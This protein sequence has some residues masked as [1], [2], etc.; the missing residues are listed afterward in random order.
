MKII[1][2]ITARSG[3][4]LIPD[5]NIRSLGGIP[6]LGWSLKALSKSK[7]VE[8]IIFSS[9]SDSYFEIAKSIN[10]EIIF[11]KRSSELAE[12]VP[13]ELV[14]LDIENK[15]EDLFDDDSIIVLIQ[16]TTPFLTSKNIDECIDKL[17]NEPRMNTSISV[18]AVEEFPEWIITTK[19]GHTDIGL[20]KDIMGDVG[21][22]QNLS[23][24]FIPNGGIYAIRQSFLK[25]E[26]KIIDNETLIYEM[27]K[28]NSIDIDNEE[29]FLICDSLIKSGIILKPE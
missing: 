8:K 23:K 13:S 29:D 22:R 26:K 18:K 16:P 2:V 11:H 12:D 3:S 28:L 27:P 4:K 25:K 21:V 15:F 17:L 10:D 24:R 1:A 9:D 6:L 19:D 5:K 20:C 14:L 7:L